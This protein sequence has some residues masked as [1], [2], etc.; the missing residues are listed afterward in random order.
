MLHIDSFLLS[1]PVNTI[2]GYRS[3]LSYTITTLMAIA[4]LDFQWP[5][6]TNNPSDEF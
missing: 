5:H 4:Y 6:S 3:I 1:N 2:D